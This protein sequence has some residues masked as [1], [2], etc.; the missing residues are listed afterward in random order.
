[1]RIVSG[2]EQTLVI[3]EGCLN[4]PGSIKDAFWHHVSWNRSLVGCYEFWVILSKRLDENGL[5]GRE[6]KI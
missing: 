3:S 6:N 4:D 1:M 5:D 2:F